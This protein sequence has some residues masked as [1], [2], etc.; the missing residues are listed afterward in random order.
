MKFAKS[1][2][3]LVAALF[4]MVALAGCNNAKVEAPKSDSQVEETAPEQKSEPAAETETDKADDNAVADKGM[5]DLEDTVYLD[6]KDGRV[7]IECFVPIWRQSMW[8]RSRHW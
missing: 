4:M 6:L 5:A 3:L 2:A 1:H 8:S 7:T